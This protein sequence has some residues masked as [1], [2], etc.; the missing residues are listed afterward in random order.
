MARYRS[1]LRKI[2][3]LNHKRR[4]FKKQIYHS[5]LSR[6]SSCGRGIGR[7]WA[8]SRFFT[9]SADHVGAREPRRNG[10]IRQI[11][12]TRSRASSNRE[13]GF[14]TFCLLIVI[15]CLID[16]LILRCE[17]NVRKSRTL[18]ISNK[19]LVVTFRRSN[20]IRQG[21]ENLQKLFPK[22]E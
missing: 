10:R 13:R 2:A 20:V 6:R 7:N 9:I 3:L 14:T 22:D 21:N 19:D 17:K 16:H 4:I 15:S 8:A 11:L 1:Q 12:A 5:R 18:Y